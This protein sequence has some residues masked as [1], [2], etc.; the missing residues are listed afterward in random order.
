[1]ILVG[2]D[3]SPDAR[4]AIDRAAVLM[5]GAEATVLTVWEPFT[6]AIL[7][8]N[9]GGMSLGGL[10]SAGDAKRIDAG[11]QESARKIAAE[12]A[13]RATA[14]GLVAHERIDSQRGG[15]GHTI[16]A[17]A[18]DVD[19]DVVVLGTRGRGGVKSFLLGS[20]SHDVV[21][22]ADR[23]VLVVPAPELAE[24]RRDAGS[25]AELADRDHVGRFSEG[26]EQLP[27]SPEKDHV[28][29]F[30]EGEEQLP[31]SPEKDHVGRFSEGEEQLPDSPGK[32]H[33]GRYSEGDAAKQRVP[34]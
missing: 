1:M 7:H 24:R 19:A 9:A 27:D 32:D 4:A 34:G 10:S 22:H 12:G 21:Q 23:S 31:D 30:S 5:P 16:L 29:R 28:G 13:E 25:R 33:V 18:A 26:E 20:V 8:G 2:Y 11:S 14:A 15:S 17:S 3:G 6:D